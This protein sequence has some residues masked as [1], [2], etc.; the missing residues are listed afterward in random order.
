MQQGGWCVSFQKVLPI[1]TQFSLQRRILS[2]PNPLSQH[3]YRIFFPKQ[4]IKRQPQI[5]SNVNAG[6][7][8]NKFGETR[9]MDEIVTAVRWIV[10]WKGN[11]LSRP[12]KSIAVNAIIMDL[13]LWGLTLSALVYSPFPRD[14]HSIWIG[15]EGFMKWPQRFT[16][17]PQFLSSLLMDVKWFFSQD[18]LI[19]SYFNHKPK[20]G[21]LSKKLKKV[22]KG[23]TNKTKKKHN[24]QI[25]QIDKRI[26]KFEKILKLEKS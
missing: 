14:D 22:C 24:E 3:F 1:P 17:L 2:I 8:S 6:S 4:D 5:V 18:N 16:I 19:F 25:S 7:P 9:G 21:G 13:L 26:F 11:A 20:D 23:R 15:N 12:F 10:G